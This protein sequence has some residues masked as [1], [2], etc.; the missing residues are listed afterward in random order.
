MSENSEA[1]HYEAGKCSK[2]CF[3]GLRLE[4]MYILPRSISWV[5]PR[6]E[7][8]NAEPDNGGVSIFQIC[9]YWFEFVA[10]IP[11]TMHRF[12]HLVY[13]AHAALTNSSAMENHGAVCI[14]SRKD[15]CSFLAL[16]R[17]RPRFNF[18]RYA[19]T[20]FEVKIPCAPNQI[21][22]QEKVFLEAIKQNDKINRRSSAEGSP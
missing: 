1:N 22:H 12:R 11:T 4:G 19:D 5:I 16:P 6:G 15:S 7:G 9:K 18:P 3:L 13:G 2:N 20:I 14:L 17:N 8:G 21:C 10:L